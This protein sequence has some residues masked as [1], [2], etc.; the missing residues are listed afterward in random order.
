MLTATFGLVT[1]DDVACQQLHCQQNVSSFTCAAADKLTRCWTMSLQGHWC[2][3]IGQLPVLVDGPVACRDFI[4]ASLTCPPAGQRADPS[5]PAA[6][7]R[8]VA[9]ALEDKT[10]DGL[11]RVH[12]FVL[13]GLGI[14]GMMGSHSADAVTRQLKDLRES[15]TQTDH[16]LR[17]RLLTSVTCLCC[18]YTYTRQ[19]RPHCTV[20]HQTKGIPA[21]TRLPLLSVM[22]TLHHVS[23]HVST[24][25]IQSV[26]MQAQLTGLGSRLDAQ[27][28]AIAS[29]QAMHI[30]TLSIPA[31]HG[32]VE[33]TIPADLAA[34]QS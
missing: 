18:V 5:D 7:Q 23:L 15:F 31:R 17:V 30:S 33:F 24:I 4:A 29:M 32:K 9:F 10:T 21:H 11:G 27:E 28:R 8:I 22:V 26:C 2:A 16:D 3:A 20:G 19:V 6:M 14:V 1:H 25:S 34:C 13:F 12:A